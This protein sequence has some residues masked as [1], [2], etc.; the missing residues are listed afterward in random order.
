M[1]MKKN[2]LKEYAKK[3]H[4]KRTPEPR[5]KK[6]KRKIDHIFVVQKH[7]ASHLHYDFRLEMN[8]VLKSW[9]IPKGPSTDPTDKRLA[10]ETED[11]P[12][13]YATFEGIIPEGEYGAGSVMVWDIGHY[14]TIKEV[15][16][17]TSWQDGHIEIVLEGKKLQGKFALIRMHGRGDK[18]W[19]FFKMKEP[20][21]HSQP[22]LDDNDRSAISD[23]TMSE[24]VRDS[25]EQSSE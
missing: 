20:N 16:M 3:R 7:A 21:S 22:S 19:L 24:I 12:L 1:V 4:F 10:V 25:H 5:P 8:G 6:E 14:R 15:P 17:E 23:R 11:H 9:A 18:N 2:S 13:D